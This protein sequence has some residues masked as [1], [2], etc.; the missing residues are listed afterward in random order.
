LDGDKVEL[1]ENIFRTWLI[2]RRLI[3]FL[4]IAILLLQHTDEGFIVGNLSSMT[5]LG[6]E[7][8]DPLATLQY[9]FSSGDIYWPLIISS[10]IIVGFY[11]IVGGRVFCS[12][13][14]PLHLVLEYTDKIKKKISMIDRSFKVSTKYW[15]LFLTLIMTLL[16]GIPV[17][18]V[19]SP[20]GMTTRALVFGTWLGL[21]FLLAISIFEIGYSRRSWCR[22]FCPLGAFYSLVGWFSL[23]RVRI[24]HGLCTKCQ[25]CKKECLVPNVLDRPISGEQKIVVSGD[26]TNC[27]ICIDVCPEKALKL[28]IRF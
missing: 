6:L 9:I 25:I 13:I 17:F 11:V 2:K 10:L 3:Q 16:A 15:I 21:L 4:I 18:E 5:I 7:L 14:C 26:C 20:I 23:I 27:A 19:L 22:Y 28:G 8:S 12:W 1:R 24:N